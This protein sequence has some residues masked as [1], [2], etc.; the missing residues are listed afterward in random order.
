MGE[1]RNILHRQ[2]MGYKMFFVL[3]YIATTKINV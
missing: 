2:D 3:L 1:W